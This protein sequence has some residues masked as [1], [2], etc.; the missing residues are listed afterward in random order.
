MFRNSPRWESNCWAGLAFDEVAAGLFWAL[1]GV[2]SVPSGP[3]FGAVSDRFGRRTGMIAVFTM[4][5]LAY[6]LVA[7][8]L[9]DAAVLASIVLFGLGAWAIPPIMAAT[10]SDYMGP[11]R[12]VRIFALVT[13][14]MGVGQMLGPAVAGALAEWQG[15]FLGGY[16]LIAGLALGAVVLVALLPRPG[17]SR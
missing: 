3:V 11:E 13:L 8:V 12:A 1:L 10:V 14:A 5:G 2:I 16:A 6:G 9:P 17:G 7:A 4:Q 15:N